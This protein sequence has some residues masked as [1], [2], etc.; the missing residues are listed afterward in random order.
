MTHFAPNNQLA[1]KPKWSPSKIRAFQKSLVQFQ[2]LYSLTNHDLAQSLSYSIQY[3][4]LMRGDYAQVRQPSQEFARRFAELKRTA[5][6][7]R[8]EY[9]LHTRAPITK[10]TSVIVNK[11]LVEFLTAT[12]AKLVKQNARL[13]QRRSQ[14][15]SHRSKSTTIK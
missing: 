5:P 11:T 7:P 1:A 8:I 2:K 12:C 10:V 6:R 14:C 3:V 13:R 9:R 15:R 4:R